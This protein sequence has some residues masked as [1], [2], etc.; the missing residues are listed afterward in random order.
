MAHAFTVWRLTEPYRSIS[1][2]VRLSAIW[3]LTEPYRTIYAQTMDEDF[4]VW[5]RFE[6]DDVDGRK[7]YGFEVDE[8]FYVVDYATA[9]GLVPW[10]EL[11]GKYLPANYRVDV[12][13]WELR[14]GVRLEMAVE[15]GEPI[16]QALTVLRTVERPRPFSR[17]DGTGSFGPSVYE[18][19]TISSEG[20][21]SLP[22][23]KLTRIAIL[24]GIHEATS[25][26]T[27]APRLQP[28][29]LEQ[30]E[31]LFLD[32][33]LAKPQRER[34][35]DESHYEKVANVYRSALTAG[36]DPVKQVQQQ[37]FLARSTAGRH[38]MEARKRGFLGPT[39]RGKAGEQTANGKDAK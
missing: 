8:S 36:L 24:A 17:G 9:D 27:P 18:K 22:V 10:I 26:G 21:R 38:V 2:S 35:R 37:F 20:L 33:Q 28:P 4:R 30:W 32:P 34:F 23:G 11:T 6:D 16:C 25:A 13:G 3:I 19:A 1:I 29:L 14:Y 31:K 7:R 39:T 5:G 12:L 15:A